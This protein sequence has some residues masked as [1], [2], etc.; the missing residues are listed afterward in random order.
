MVD[1]NEVLWFRLSFARVVPSL[2]AYEI[3]Q[4]YNFLELGVYEATLRF[5]EFFA[6]L[7]RGVEEARIDFTNDWK[8][9]EE[10]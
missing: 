10:S 8:S 7:S 9:S 4:L 2:I 3:L 6:L 1:H 5:D